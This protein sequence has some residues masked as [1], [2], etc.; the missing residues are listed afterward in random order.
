MREKIW[1]S[2]SKL[3]FDLAELSK[4]QCRRANTALLLWADLCLVPA[5]GWQ[6]D[7]WFLSW[8]LTYFLTY[9]L[10]FC[11]AGIALY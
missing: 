4:M 3:L 2:Y 11:T 9:F 7:L 8:K 10:T 1:G 6:G 5:W